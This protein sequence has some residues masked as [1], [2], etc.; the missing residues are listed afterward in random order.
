MKKPGFFKDELNGDVISEFVGLRAKLYCINSEKSTIK[1]AKGV[2]KSVN[3]KLD[4]CRYKNALFFN[5][6]LRDD[7]HVIRSK[8]H[9]VFTQKINK[10]V[11]CR[12]CDQIMVNQIE[13]LPWGHYSN[14]V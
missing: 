2:T 14:I 9:K 5:E 7:M 1:K 13:T 12:I 4:L 8:N 10:L 6:C 11:L 3:K